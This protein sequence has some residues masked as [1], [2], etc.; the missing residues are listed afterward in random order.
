[1]SRQSKGLPQE[2][3][4]FAIADRWPGASPEQVLDW[5]EEMIEEALHIMAAEARHQASASHE[6]REGILG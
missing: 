4:H 6:R 5:D 2:L 3:V 1:M